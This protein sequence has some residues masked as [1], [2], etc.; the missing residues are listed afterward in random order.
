MFATYSLPF[1]MIPARNLYSAPPVD[2]RRIDVVLPVKNDNPGLVRTLRSLRFL[3]PKPRRVIIVDG[4]KTP[5]AR[6]WAQV[7]MQ[8]SGIPIQV[9]NRP[10]DVGPARARNAGL[11]Q[12][13]GWVYLTDADCVHARGT[14]A[15]LA[16]ER[17]ESESDVVAVAGPVGG[18][19]EGPVARYMTEQ[20]N[21]SPPFDAGRPQAFVTA[22]VLLYRPAVAAAGWFDERFPAAGGEDFDLA[23]RMLRLGRIG[24]APQAKVFHHFREDLGAFDERFHR[25]GVGLRLLGHKWGADFSPYRFRAAS[26]E[27]QYLADRQFEMMRAGYESASSPGA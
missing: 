1:N 8:D 17:N 22:S 23:F 16:R 14:L 11:R 6:K 2:L 27:L 18:Q 12:A 9:L 25:Y 21:L 13:K 7:E 26:A 5:R 20:G 3:H 24:W 15:L 10:N 19:G 4:S